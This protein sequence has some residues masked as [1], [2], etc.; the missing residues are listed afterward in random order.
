MWYKVIPGGRLIVMQ[1]SEFSGAASAQ[2]ERQLSVSVINSIDLLSVQELK[3]VVLH[4]GVLGH[5]SDLSSGGVSSDAIAESENV[6]ESGMLQSVLVH[7][8]HTISVCKTRIVKPLERFARRVDASTEEWLFN[9]LTGVHVAEGGDFLVVLI[10]VQLDHFP[11]EAHINVSLGT[12]VESDFVCVR[13]GVDLFVRSEVLNSGRLRV[14]LMNGIKSVDAFV[15]R[16]IEVTSF[17]LVREFRRICDEI[18]SALS[19]SIPPVAGDTFLVVEE[20][21]E[22]VIDFWSGFHFWEALDVVK[23]MLETWC[24]HESLVVE[25]FAIVKVNRVCVRINFFNHDTSFDSRPRINHT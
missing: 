13:E 19:E 14:G 24:D 1:V 2:K 15:V 16:G 25:H 5:G 17:S 9:G 7:V 4:N 20:M 3:H 18:A 23:S 22:D 11:A 8:N 10:S 6:L 21:D 12:F